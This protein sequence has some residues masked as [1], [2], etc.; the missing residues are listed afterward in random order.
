M[1]EMSP[2]DRDTLY[3]LTRFNEAMDQAVSESITRFS[4]QLD[5]S[6]ELFLGVLGHDL[7]SPLGAVL[8]SARYLLHAEGLSGAQTKA[9]SAILRSGVR[10]QDMIS[11][12]LDVARTRLGQSL[13]IA[14]REAN[15]VHT[16]HAVVDEAQAHHPEQILRFSPS[17][18]LAGTWDEA[19]VGQMLSNLIE[20]AIRYGAPDKPVTVS[21]SGAEDHVR[22][23][24]HNEGTPIPQAARHRI[25]E[26]L[27]QEE[28]DPTDP[29]RAGSIGLG[30]HIARA[31]AQAHGGSIDFESSKEKG[32][33]F[34]VLLPRAT[35]PQQRRSGY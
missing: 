19:R 4:A 33:T 20:N 14:I 15:L 34:I 2:A 13:P 5:R 24:V 3:E 32:T 9:V 7:R 21:A 10:L 31:I 29:R 12:L 1:E 30:L 17:G 18:D 27:A 28:Q 25:F 6:R 16:C 26:P 23:T 8:N 22:L 35:Q 11:D